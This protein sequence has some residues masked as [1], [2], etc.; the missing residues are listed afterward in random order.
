MTKDEIKKALRCCKEQ[1]C[2]DCPHWCEAGCR[3]QT[4][5][6]ALEL[7][8]EQEKEIERLKAENE[9]LENNMRAVLEK[10]STQ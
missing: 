7:I 1:A 5:S 2:C 9:Q 4:L 3:Y 6:D 10:L 8:A